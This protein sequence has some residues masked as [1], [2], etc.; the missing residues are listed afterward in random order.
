MCLDGKKHTHGCL[1][2]RAAAFGTNSPTNQIIL[3]VVA[4][5]ISAVLLIADGFGIVKH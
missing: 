4:Q 2:F 3:Q 1:R 5:I